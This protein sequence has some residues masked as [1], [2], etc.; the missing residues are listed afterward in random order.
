MRGASASHFDP[1]VLAAF[2]Q[3]KQA[4]SDIFESFVARPAEAQLRE[5]A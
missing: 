1:A 3:D 4:F 2:S 5:T